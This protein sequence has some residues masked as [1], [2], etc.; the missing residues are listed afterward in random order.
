MK[1]YFSDEENIA[2]SGDSNYGDLQDNLFQTTSETSQVEDGNTKSSSTQHSKAQKKQSIQSMYHF[3]T[4]NNYP[5]NFLE[6]LEPFLKEKCSQWVF[7]KEMGVNGTPHIQG[8][9]KLKKTNRW[10]SFGLPRDIHWEKIRNKKA[11]FEYCAKEDTRVGE[12]YW[13]FPPTVIKAKLKLITELRPWQQSILAQLD[14]DPDDRTVNWVY[15][16][17]GCMGKTVFSK[18]LYAKKNAII[19]TGGGNKDIACL[20]ALL[21]EE[22]ERD[23]N[24]KTSFVFNFPRSTEGISYKAIESVKDGLMTSVKYKTSTLVFNCPHVWCFSN[25]L[26]DYNKLSRDRWM[27]WTIK[28]GE[29][30]NYFKSVDGTLTLEL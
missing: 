18:Y 3:F 21:V 2:T 16:T 19:A 6:I 1:R 30:V 25:E 24:Q 20:I 13:S 15:D 11:A 8:S 26:P 29:L 10:E 4:W 23:L 28:N 12:N 9:I 5:E 14:E 27:I 7:Q 17:E 22:E